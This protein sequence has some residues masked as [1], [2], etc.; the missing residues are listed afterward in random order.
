[1]SGY[2]ASIDNFETL[3]LAVNNWA[4]T[5]AGTIN[6]TVTDIPINA[7]S[8]QISKLQTQ[9]GVLSIGDEVLLYSYI[10]TSGATP[11]LR[12]CT[13][14]I[15]GTV[16]QAHALGERVEVRWTARH[17]NQ[18][19]L[20][21]IAIQTALGTD[22]I[23]DNVDLAAR[24]DLALPKQVAFPSSQLWEFTHER[25]RIVQVQAYRKV[26][27]YTYEKVD[28][29]VTQAIGTPCVVQLQFDANEEGYV[30]YA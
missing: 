10:D 7:S 22:I 2:P 18:V 24:L 6:S 30:L 4:A 11:V 21:L 20:S 28:V 13:R 16:A 14:G 17:H 25:G 29:P 12:N 15:D 23:G 26:A 5:V 19:A 9:Y 8:G 1:M 27:D 3:L